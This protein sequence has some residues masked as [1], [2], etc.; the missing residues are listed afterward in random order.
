MDISYGKLILVDPNGPEQEFVLAKASVSLG[1]ANTN[2]IILN[3]VRVSRSHARLEYGPEGIS[4]VDMGSSNGTRLNGIRVER[5]TLKPGDTISLGSQQLK[6]QV[7]SPSEDVGMTKIDN[8]VQLD[9]TINTEY[10]PTVINETSSPSLVIFTEDKTWRVD[11]NDLDQAMIGR[12]ESCAVYIDAPN[13]SRRHAEVQQKGGAFILVDLGSTNGTFVR[14]QQIEQHI[15]KDGDVF[16]IGSAQIAFKG[17]FQEQALT[18]SHGSP[19]DSAG[20]RTV[21]FV[22]GLMG[23]ELWLGTERIWP[24]VKTIFTNPEIYLYPSNT[25]LEPRSIVDEVVIVPNLIKLDQYNRLGDYLVEELDYRRGVDFFEFPYD[26]RQDVRISARQLGQMIDSLSSPRPLVIIGHS[27]GTMVS[28]YY[29]EHLGGHKHVDRVIL[30]GGPHKGAVKGLTSMLVA[31]EVLPFGIMGERLRQIVLS[32]PSSYQILPNY[33]VGIDQNGNQ[34]NFI[35]DQDWLDAKYLPLLEMGREFR[36]E[37]GTS[38][39]IPSVAIFGYG[40]KTISSVT[41]VRDASGKLQK[42]DYQTDNIGDGSVLEQSAFLSGSE[43]HPV[44]QH[45]GALFVDNDVKMRLKLELTR[46]Y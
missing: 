14:G 43:I 36:K 35:E 25:P 21:V 16:Q 24:N 45:H 40:L 17:G 4:L 7:E 20:R 33:A 6:F 8:Q 22:P 27:L 9:Q 41:V 37:L 18:L 31:P 12:D 30:M 19:M 29:I 34:I 3:D 38:A 11:L 46:P 13:V 28:R 1:R 23:S 15:L 44:H 26:W 32:F 5:A 42:V 10:L 2:D 39:S